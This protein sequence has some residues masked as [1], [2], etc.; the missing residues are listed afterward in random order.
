[1]PLTASKYGKGRVRVM[2]LTRDGDHHTPRELNITALMK[3]AFDASWTEGDNRACVA[4]DS[5]KNICNV[6]A[7]KN[8]SLDKEAFIEAVA[9]LFLDTYPQVEQMQIEAKE[10]RWRRHAFD[11]KPHGHVFTLDGNGFGYVK[12][13]ASRDKAVLQSGLRGF[14]FMKTTQSGWVDF[15]NDEYRTLA[16]TTDRIAA[17]AMDATWTWLSAPADY[18]TTNAKVLDILIE[19]F[20]TTYSYGVQDSMYRMAEAVLAA[21]PEIADIS[22]AMPNKHYIPINLA[23]FGLENPGAVFLPTDEPHG[24]IEATISRG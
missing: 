23:P 2:R 4:T 5:V 8:I 11:G 10:T 18:T 22:F 16:D 15:V 7:A 9:K 12:L 21:V 20:G 1:M 19:V 14:T 24:Q 6:V 13:V 3:G 17:T